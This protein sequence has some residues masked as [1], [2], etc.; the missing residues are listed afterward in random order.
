MKNWI[1]NLDLSDD[2]KKNLN[3][4]LNIIENNPEIYPYVMTGMTT[5]LFE[6]K[7]K[8]KRRN[9]NLLR[10]AL[11]D[12]CNILGQKKLPSLKELS[13]LY[14]TRIR[15][16]IFSNG[17]ETYHHEGEKNFFKKMGWDRDDKKL[18]KE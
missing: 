17:I 2:N 11:G 8:C 4:I 1:Q 18:L 12:A 7:E 13:S 16:A 15:K 14:C 3:N 10:E 5:I 9:D 6:F